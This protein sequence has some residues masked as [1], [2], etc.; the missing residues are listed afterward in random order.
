V[1]NFFTRPRGEAMR[2]GF[3]GA[4]LRGSAIERILTP[5]SL[6][7]ANGLVKPAIGSCSP[8]RKAAVFTNKESGTNRFFPPREG[9][10]PKGPCPILWSSWRVSLSRTTLNVHPLGF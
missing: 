6:F 1:K 5:L 8:G 10:Y 7:H 3:S 4:D 9:P 2:R